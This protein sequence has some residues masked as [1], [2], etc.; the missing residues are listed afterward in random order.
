MLKALKLV[1]EHKKRQNRKSPKKDKGFSQRAGSVFYERPVR[2]GAV[3]REG[4]KFAFARR[5]L[6]PTKH[7]S[8]RNARTENRRD[9]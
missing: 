2:S 1:Y 9:A 7:G 5:K 6:L 8:D 4:E 3:Y